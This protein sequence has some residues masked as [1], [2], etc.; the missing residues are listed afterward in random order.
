VAASFV[1]L[2]ELLRKQEALVC[3]CWNVFRFKFKLD[4]FK[5]DDFKTKFAEE[6]DDKDEG[7]FELDMEFDD[8]EDNDE[9]SEAAVA[10]AAAAWFM[11]C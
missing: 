9:E 4:E 5:R 10:T 8:D 2:V 1:V 11:R 3:N 7:E 6:G